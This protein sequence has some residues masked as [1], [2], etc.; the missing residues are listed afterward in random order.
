MA[1]KR[2]EIARSCGLVEMIGKYCIH[3]DLGSPKCQRGVRV[4]LG[5]LIRGIKSIVSSKPAETAWTPV[6]KSPGFES[7]DAAEAMEI[8]R[9]RQDHLASLGL[10]LANQ[11]VLEVG[12][13]VGWHTLFFERLGCTVLSTDARPENVREHLRRYPH[14]AGRVEVADL[15][16]PGSH[17]RFGQFDFVYC[18]GTLYHL[19]NPALCIRDLSKICRRFFLLETCVN[20]QDNGRINLVREDRRYPNQSFHGLGCRPGRDWVMAELHR[21][22]ASAYVTVTQPDHPEFPLTWP[23]VLLPGMQNARAVFVAS[24]ETLDLPT[25]S[26]RLLMQQQRIQ[27]TPLTSGESPDRGRGTSQ[28][29]KDGAALDPIRTSGISQ[30]YYLDRTRSRVESNDVFLGLHDTTKR[31]HIDSKARSLIIRRK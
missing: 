9:A 21:H 19:S 17:D 27:P 10:N 12:A 8:N 31:T 29:I 2:C 13:G 23:V 11:S 20:P 22:F 28:T 14:R 7:F 25:L 3:T 5:E 6:L 15:T 24:R 18:Y 4:R 30:A 26:P 16:V 1:L